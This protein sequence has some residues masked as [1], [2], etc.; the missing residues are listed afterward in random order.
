[1]DGVINNQQQSLSAEYL[2]SPSTTS[3]TTYKIQ[4]RVA[5]GTSYLNRAVADT[6]ASYAPRT[7][8]TITVMEIAG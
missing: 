7:V 6:D 4:Y 2:D 3:A 5:G 1:M 8:S